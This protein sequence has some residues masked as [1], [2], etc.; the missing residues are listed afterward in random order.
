V[1][2]GLGASS[3]IDQVE[4][5]WPS[6]NKEKFSVPGVDRIIKLVEGE[7]VTEK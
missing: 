7:G 4:V 1:H 2:F 5:H 6:G 3:T